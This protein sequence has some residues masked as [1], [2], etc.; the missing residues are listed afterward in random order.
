MVI[1]INSTVKDFESKSRRWPFF[2]EFLL[3]IQKKIDKL[4]LGKGFY[5]S[6]D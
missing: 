1:A 3:V 2:T 6:I 4:G 5:I